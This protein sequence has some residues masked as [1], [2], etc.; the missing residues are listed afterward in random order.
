MVMSV[1]AGAAAA[2]ILPCTSPPS[3]CE[4]PRKV[5]PP[6]ATGCPLRD[7]AGL[8]VELVE[9]R[10]DPRPDRVPRRA[11]LIDGPALRV[12]ELPLDVALT[13]DVGAGVAAPHRHH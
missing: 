4:Q 10:A 11:D 7:L 13:R 2:I 5:G 6:A 1:A 9:E 3:E 12:V 8:R